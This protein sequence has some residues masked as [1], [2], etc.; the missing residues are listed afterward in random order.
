M[1]SMKIKNRMYLFT[2]V[3][4]VLYIASRLLIGGWLTIGVWYLIIIPPI[5]HLI[6]HLKFLKQ[7][8]EIINLNKGFLY[9]SHLILIILTL[10]QFDFGD[11]PYFVFWSEIINFFIKDF[12]YLIDNNI[13]GNIW[14]ILQAILFIFY[15]IVES[16]LT[17]KFRKIRLL[18]KR[19]IA[20]K[21]GL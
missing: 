19:N 17:Y 7:D 9:L 18:A 21:I 4:I 11:G 14:F 1:K 20:R 3:S 13:D 2:I 6:I 5:W 12:R 10:F 8:L 16:I 15:L